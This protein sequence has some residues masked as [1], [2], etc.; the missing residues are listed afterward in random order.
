MRE[1]YNRLPEK[2]KRL[3]AGIEALKLLYG[4]IS[5]IAELFGCSR[6]TISVGIKELAEAETLPKNRN[7]KQVEAGSLR[8]KMNLIL[9]TFFWL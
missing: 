4:G 9:M 7:R 2:S 8:L 6:D 1:L 3:Y 5:Y